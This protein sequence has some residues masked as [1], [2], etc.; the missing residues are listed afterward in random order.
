MSSSVFED[1]SGRFKSLSS[2]LEE[3]NLKY[4]TTQQEC[5][6][7][8]SLL[9]VSYRESIHDKEAFENALHEL[10]AEKSYN[11]LL[12]VEYSGVVLELSHQKALFVSFAENENALKEQLTKLKSEHRDTLFGNKL[13]DALEEENVNMKR[14][15]RDLNNL[16]SGL[17]GQL[18]LA[19]D[20]CARKDT[21]ILGHQNEQIASYKKIAEVSMLLESIKKENLE[22]K[23]EVSLVKQFDKANKAASDEYLD[24]I[25]DLVRELKLAQSD[26]EIQLLQIRS[27]EDVVSKNKEVIAGLNVEI[28]EFKDRNGILQSEKEKLTGE[29]VFVK[30][31]LE[32][33]EQARAADK[34]F[35]S[36]IENLGSDVEALNKKLDDAQTEIKSLRARNE[37]QA[38][39]IM[40]LEEERNALSVAHGAATDINEKLHDLEFENSKLKC[41]LDVNQQEF[42]D[43]YKTF[44]GSI[45][46]APSAPKKVGRV[47]ESSQQTK[48]QV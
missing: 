44:E 45:S 4:V 18:Q 29:I 31:L 7:V 22:L 27:L 36:S 25:S 39:H 12:S 5:S 32:S 48:D 47:V 13:M 40:D 23:E 37:R 16:V 43:L 26:I 24:K 19:E 17:Q 21:V 42:T 6:E 35:L 8:K 30:K 10:A 41:M 38:E 11:D 3:L 28:Q 15:I 1:F 2:Q 14:Q 34:E 9:D 46:H 20:C 33:S